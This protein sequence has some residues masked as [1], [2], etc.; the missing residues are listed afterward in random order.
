MLWKMVA[1][2]GD[3]GGR[4]GGYSILQDSS[5]RITTLCYIFSVI[6]AIQYAREY[7]LQS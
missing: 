6:P 2:G 3:S 5:L 1:G 7:S 4:E